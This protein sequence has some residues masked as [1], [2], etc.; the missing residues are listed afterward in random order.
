[1]G[2]REG[3]GKTVSVIEI[4]R[5]PA[6]V[7]TWLDKKDKFNQWVSWVTDVKDGGPD[8]VGGKRRTTMRDRNMNN[9]SVYVDAVTTEFNRPAHIKV[10]IT[11]PMGFEG[12]ASYDLEDLNGRTRL[13]AIGVFKYSEWFATLLEPVITPQAKV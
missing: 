5:P 4:N 10:Y 9:Q 2:R 1:M 8:G 3:A 12:D 6:Q 13:T 7:W 11:S